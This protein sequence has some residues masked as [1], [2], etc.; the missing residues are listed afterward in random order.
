[1]TTIDRF[2]RRPAGQQF[3]DP[4]IVRFLFGN[5]RM[6][7]IWLIVR[8]YLG[9]QWLSA[10]REK[11]ASDGWMKTG[12]SLKGFWQHAVAAPVGGTKGIVHYGWFHSLLQYMLQ[13]Q[14]YT[15]FAKLV[16]IG[17]TTIGVLLIVGAFVGVAAFFGAFLNFNFMLAG[18]AS[19]NP[20]LFVLALLLVLA[21]KIAGYCGLDYV[22]LPRIGVPWQN[23]GIF[24][25]VK[26]GTLGG[27]M[28][29]G[30]N[31]KGVRQ[32]TVDVPDGRIANRRELVDEIGP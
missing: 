6:A 13:H 31:F 15:W 21:W 22:L 32:H 16:A 19:T 17:E 1:M 14:W 5:A 7:W 4:G 29:T 2:S 11:L 28:K 24:G 20:V 25:R 12:A 9:Y 23:R 30:T 8:L 18:S 3:E 10:G 26:S 27:W